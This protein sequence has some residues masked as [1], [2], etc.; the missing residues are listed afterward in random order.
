MRTSLEPLPPVTRRIDSPETEIVK[1]VGPDTYPIQTVVH[2]VN[3][4]LDED[5]RRTSQRSPCCSESC[6]KSNTN[7]RVPGTIFC[8]GLGDC[9]YLHANNNTSFMCLAPLTTDRRSS[10]TQEPSANRANLPRSEISPL[11]T[12]LASGGATGNSYP[13]PEGAR[14]GRQ[15]RQEGQGEKSKAEKQ[16]TEGQIEK[17]T[18][19][20]EAEDALANVR[21]TG[22]D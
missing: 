20:A 19:E 11:E 18:G 10:A 7:T 8:P 5:P 4:T 16:E 21:A 6:S 2:V 15:R 22:V 17:A 13:P 14:N 9:L 3:A 12:V 1:I